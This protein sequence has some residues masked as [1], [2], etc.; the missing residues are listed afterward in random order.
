[1]HCGSSK[2]AKERINTFKAHFEKDNTKESG[3]ECEYEDLQEYLIKDLIDAGKNI[4][5]LEKIKEKADGRIKFIYLFLSTLCIGLCI[6]LEEISAMIASW[7]L[8]S[9]CVHE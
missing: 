9:V 5:Q 7:R 1:M 2:T 4:T 8:G 6:A 3:G